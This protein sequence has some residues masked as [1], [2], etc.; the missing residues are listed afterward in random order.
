MRRALRPFIADERGLTLIELMMATALLSLVLAAAAAAL[1]SYQRTAA[2]SDVRLENLSEAEAIMDVVGRDI[3]TATR[4]AAGESP[5]VYAGATEVRFYANLRTTTGPKLVRLYVDTP[6]GRVIEES[7][8]PTG[9]PP[10]SYTSAPV[11][12]V[13]GRHFANDATQPL[14]TYVDDEGNV[15]SGNPLSSDQRLQIDAVRID[16]S[17]RKSTSLSVRA[18]T[19]RTTVRLP[20]VE[21]TPVTTP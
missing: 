4:P 15:L 12:R 18:T 14:L 8:E 6:T 16:L 13:V 2:S 7:I 5:F 20:N 11:L 19:V 10:Y 3:R 21:Y 9:S 1:A 17:I